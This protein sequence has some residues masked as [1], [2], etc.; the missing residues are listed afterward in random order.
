MLSNIKYFGILVSKNKAVE[1]PMAEL[2]DFNPD[3]L[4][5]YRVDFDVND[6]PYE[7]VVIYLPVYYSNPKS[8]IK[9][10]GITLYSG[11]SSL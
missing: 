4:A 1:L 10:S 5:I 8:L 6:M 2:N 3:L 7:D 11:T 9:K